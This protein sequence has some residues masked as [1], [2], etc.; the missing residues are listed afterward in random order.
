VI[1][2]AFGGQ[3]GPARTHTPMD[4]WDLRLQ[5][6]RHATFAFAEGHTVAMVVLHGTVLF[7]GSQVAR[8]GQMVLFDRTAG[9]VALEA[10][11]DATVLVLAGEP[12]DEPIAG[13]GPF[14]MNSAGRDPHR[15]HGLQQRPLRRDRRLNAMTGV[16][17]GH[18]G[19]GRNP[20]LD[21][22]SIRPS[23]AP[24]LK[25]KPPMNAL[26]PY[27]QT[28]TAQRPVIDPNDAVML[29]IDHQSGLFQ[30]VA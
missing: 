10:N 7:N 18:F 17:P 11:A 19:P 1:A 14:V 28:S 27:A 25:G 23:A 16:R 30:T 4:V 22:C 6:D 21:R 20:R 13:Y 9:E 24:C 15:R 26:P 12:I 5:R 29:L 3:H 8:E 2:G